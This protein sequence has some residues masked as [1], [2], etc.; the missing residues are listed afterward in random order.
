MRIYQRAIV[1]QVLK[2]GTFRCYLRDNEA[3]QVNAHLCGNMRR[4]RILLCAGDE[5]T[6]ELSPYNLH[7]GRVIWRQP[8]E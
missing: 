6:L 5:V 7:H 4:H 8:V 2:G 1:E 3:H